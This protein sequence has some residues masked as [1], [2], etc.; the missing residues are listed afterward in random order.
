MAATEETA[1]D[2]VPQKKKKEPTEIEKR[3]KKIVPGS[4]MKAEMRPGGG[5]ARPSD[6]DQVLYHCTVRTLDGVIVESSRA[7]Y[8]GKGTPIRQ[9]LDKSKMLL[10][11]IEGLPTMLKGEV[12]MFK[13]KP[14]MHYGEAD[15]PLSPPSSFPK[16]DELHFEIEMI[17][18]S[19]VKVVSDDLGITKKVMRT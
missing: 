5:D 17:D 4:L 11:L 15:C 9:V 3:R 2:Y 7:E 10:G 18:F 19:K 16:D 8:G 1:Q 14:Q 12:A 6:G 13:M